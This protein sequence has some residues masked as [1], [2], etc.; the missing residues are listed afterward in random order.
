MLKIIKSDPSPWRL[1]D[2]ILFS[3]IIFGLFIIYGLSQKLLNLS[4]PNIKSIDSTVFY[5]IFILVSFPVG[6]YLFIYRPRLNLGLFYHRIKIKTLITIVILTIPF[7]FYELYHLRYQLFILEIARTFVN[8]MKN[9]PQNSF[10]EILKINQ[11]K[12]FGSLIIAPFF[13]EF[14]FRG[15]GQPYLISRLG[16]ILGVII[17][18][19]LFTSLHW[20]N[21]DLGDSTWIWLSALGRFIESLMFG[22]VYLKTKNLWYSTIMH[23]VGNLFAFLIIN[24]IRFNQISWIYELPF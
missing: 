1:I 4:I 11:T 24:V 10:F 7:L 14:Y 17:T 18:A 2:F 19:L 6:Y 21:V 13:E 9:L 12:L 8:E 23:F 22:L 5:I 3:V 15:I 16:K 20:E